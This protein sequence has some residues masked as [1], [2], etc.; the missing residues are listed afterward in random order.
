MPFPIHH[1]YTLHQLHSLKA[2]A[3][4]P[5]LITE[6]LSYQPVESGQTYMISPVN[7]ALY[8]QLILKK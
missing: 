3:E 5:Y 8:F 2:H 4:L 7:L 6:I 1:I